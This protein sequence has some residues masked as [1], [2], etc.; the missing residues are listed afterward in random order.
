MVSPWNGARPVSMIQ[1]GAERIDVTEAD[2]TVF[3]EGLLRRDVTRRAEVWPVTVRSL[4]ESR[5]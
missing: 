2:I 3:A 5:L 4:F 1:D